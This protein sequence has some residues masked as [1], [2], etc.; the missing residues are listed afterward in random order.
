MNPIGNRKLNQQYGVTL[1]DSLN[2]VVLVPVMNGYYL[3]TSNHD[4]VKM[5]QKSSIVLVGSWKRF[6]WK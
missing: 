5:D 4:E 6:S 3:E 1:W 2:Q